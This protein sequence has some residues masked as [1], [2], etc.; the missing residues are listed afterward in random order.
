M[1][2]DILEP[3]DHRFFW[4]MCLCPTAPTGTSEVDLRE[5]IGVLESKTTLQ[6]FCGV[7]KCVRHE[8]ARAAISNRTWIPKYRLQEPK[9]FACQCKQ[10]LDNQSLHS[11]PEA[12]PAALPRTPTT[13]GPSAARKTAEC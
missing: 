4:Q 3:S 10:E 11:A 8:H 7:R 13:P 1:Y 12:P 5:N 6:N 2:L 9:S